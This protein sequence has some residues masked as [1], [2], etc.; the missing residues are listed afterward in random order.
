MLAVERLSGADR[1]WLM[2]D[3]P[4]NRMTIVSLVIYSRPFPVGDLRALV[5]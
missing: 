4:T 1:A 3:R 2:M 5:E